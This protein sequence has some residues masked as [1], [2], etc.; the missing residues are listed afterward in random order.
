MSWHVSQNYVTKYILGIAFVFLVL[1]G[2]MQVFVFNHEIDVQTIHS[3]YESALEEYAR[4]NIYYTPEDIVQYIRVRQNPS[5]YF[6]LNPD[7]IF[8][9]S[10]LNPETLEATRFAVVTLDTLNH[11]YVINSNATVHYVL[12][13]Y[14]NY[15]TPEGNFTGFQKYQG[16][17]AGVRST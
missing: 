10:Q 3:E 12:S 13:N 15:S 7:L 17:S 9:P 8:E 11:T 5:G 6:V 16:Y 14:V 1:G 4:M 2:I